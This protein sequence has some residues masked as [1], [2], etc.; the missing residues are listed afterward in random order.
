MRASIEMVT[1]NR[2]AARG[3]AGKAIGA[4]SMESQNSEI[5]LPCTLESDG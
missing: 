2:S 1:G 4:R 5:A 3:R